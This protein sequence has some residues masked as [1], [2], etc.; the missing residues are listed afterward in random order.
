MC[1]AAKEWEEVSP[2]VNG[3]VVPSSSAGQAS[4]EGRVGTAISI[5]DVPLAILVRNV[6]N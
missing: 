5:E 3:F 2:K 4:G 1:H 6:A